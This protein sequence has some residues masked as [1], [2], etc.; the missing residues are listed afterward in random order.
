[1]CLLVFAWL[2]EYWLV[3]LIAVLVP[4]FDG[5]SSGCWRFYSWVKQDDLT[6]AQSDR[7]SLDNA[8]PKAQCDFALGFLLPRRDLAW[9]RGGK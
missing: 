9:P 3:W 5:W 1:M 8:D 7:L 6:R 2:I 4:L